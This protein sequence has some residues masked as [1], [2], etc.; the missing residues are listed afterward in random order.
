MRTMSV[1]LVTV[2]LAGTALA[3]PRELTTRVRCDLAGNGED[4]IQVER[5]C[6]A[7]VGGL[8]V[9]AGDE[10][11]LKLE[12]GTIR[13]F[14]DEH[15]ACEQQNSAK[16][17]LYRLAA[18]YPQQK[19]FVIEQLAYESSRFIVVNGRSGSI[20]RM[21]VLPHLAPSGKR[22]V[23]AAAVEAWEVEK[24]IAIYSVRKDKIDLEWSYKA[25]DYEM[26]SFVSWNGDDRVKLKVQLWIVGRTGERVLATQ[27]AELRRTNAGWLLNKDVKR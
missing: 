2:L 1:A 6:L 26:W 17:L 16:C 10:L 25:P 8:A 9:R 7:Q 13:T 24:E 21:D 27:P 5:H 11:R 15:Q 23:T 4:S 12:N 14:T 18:Y 22:L 19:L 3:Q 20:A